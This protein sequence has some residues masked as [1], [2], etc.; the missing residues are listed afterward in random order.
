M[1]MAVDYPFGI[2]QTKRVFV[3]QTPKKSKNLTVKEKLCYG[4]GDVSHG[5]AFSSVGIF[6]LKYLTDVAGLQAKYAGWAMIFGRVW[7]AVTDP[8]MGWITDHTETRWG[9][10]RPFLLFGAIPY[11]LAFL[12]LWVVPEFENQTEIFFY[13]TIVLLVFNTCLTFVFV[14]YTSLTAAI[15]NDYNE[16]TSLTGYRITSSQTAQFVGGVFPSLLIPFVMTDTG[17]ELMTSIGLDALLG[18]WHGTA[19]AGYAAMAVIFAILMAISVLNF[20]FLE[21]LKEILKRRKINVTVNL[22]RKRRSKSRLAAHLIT[23][24]LFS[25]N[26]KETVH[27]RFQY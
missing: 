13:V 11:A 15:T 16:R 27:F 17:V 5:L 19:R 14:P 23:H 2:I 6:F 3:S 12:S 18:D 7:D 9:K 24:L 25:M 26:Y 1:L 4:L 21:Q 22:V 10:R 20:F 8:V